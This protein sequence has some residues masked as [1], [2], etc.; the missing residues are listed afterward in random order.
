MFP[1]LSSNFCLSFPLRP[2]SNRL[3]RSPNSL[4]LKERVSRLPGHVDVD[5]CDVSIEHKGDLWR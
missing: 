4:G 5:T 2:R 1:W 3:F